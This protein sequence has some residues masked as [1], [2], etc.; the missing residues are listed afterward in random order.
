M[1]IA[2]YPQRP[3]PTIEIKRSAVWNSNA[4][5]LAAIITQAVPIHLI[6]SRK[7]VIIKYP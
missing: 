4:R 7:L 5:Q 6:I 1:A 3:A 2:A